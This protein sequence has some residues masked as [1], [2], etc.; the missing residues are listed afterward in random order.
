[1]IA[2]VDY[3]VNNLASVV[4]ALAA[5]GHPGT[6]TADPDAVRRA[7]RVLMPGVGHF[8]RAAANLRASGLG[9][10]VQEVARAGRPVMCICLGLQLFYASSAEAPDTAGLGLLDGRVARFDTDLPVPHVGWAEVRLTEAGRRHPV[11]AA[12]MPDGA[13]FY[14]HVHSFHPAD[15]PAGQALATGNYGAVFPTFVGK[16]NVLGAQFHPE[17]SQQAGIRL[18]AAFA[19]WT[20]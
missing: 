2:V 9:E 10:A 8:A 20:P 15:V 1:M 6:L 19:E 17:K 16:G 3:E 4:R 14:Y 11:A 7:D 18:L 13:E 5:G 12:V